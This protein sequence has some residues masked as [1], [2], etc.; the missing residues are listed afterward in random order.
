MPRTMTVVLVVANGTV[1][2]NENRCAIADASA[3][4]QIE[5]PL[6]GPASGRDQARYP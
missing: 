2:L 3:G 1:Q 4:G 6:I 5:V